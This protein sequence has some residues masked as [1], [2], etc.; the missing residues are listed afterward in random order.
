[1][2]EFSSLPTSQDRG[3]LKNGN[4]GGNI[5]IVKAGIFFKSISHFYHQF[6]LKE[7]KDSENSVLTFKF[8]F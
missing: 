3:E 2:N 6:G 1:M 5:F 8:L 4:S 7:Q